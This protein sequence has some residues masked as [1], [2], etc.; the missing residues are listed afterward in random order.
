MFPKVV[1]VHNFPTDLT[2]V[3]THTLQIICVYFFYIL[4]NLNKSF[5]KVSTVFSSSLCSYEYWGLKGTESKILSGP[6]IFFNCG[7]SLE[8]TCTL[9]NPKQWWIMPKFNMLYDKIKTTMY[10]LLFLRNTLNVYNCDM[11][12]PLNYVLRPCCILNWRIISTIFFS[13]LTMNELNSYPIL[14]RFL[15]LLFL[16]LEV[17]QVLE[18]G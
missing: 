10:F 12:N 1:G 7:F 13:K 4:T 15:I 14:M 3:L 17:L 16:V 2:R 9:I 8:V 6:L 5:Y 18:V 11:K